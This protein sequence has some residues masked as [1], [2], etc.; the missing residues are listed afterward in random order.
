MKHAFFCV[1]IFVMSM[2]FTQCAPSRMVK[3]L[4]EKQHAVTANLG[5]P[6]IGFAGTVIPIPFTALGYGYG[7]RANT[8]VFGN[9]HTTSLLYGVVQ[10]DL[11][12]C[13]NFKTW[14]NG[15]AIS[16]NLV[17]NVA[18]DK[19]QRNFRFWP[20]LDVNVYKPFHE[21]KSF[22]YAGFDSW[23]ELSR[24]R[25]HDYRQPVAV[26]LN[27]HAGLQWGKKTHWSYQF[28]TKWLIPYIKNSPNQIKYKAPGGNGA[29][30]V[31]FGVTYRFAQKNQ[32][33]NSTT[34]AN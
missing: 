32:E 14:E 9:V 6:L 17:A 12:I 3:P 1:V 19:W 4:A 25:A 27:P 5:G 15:L 28:E 11:G 2:L 33:T 16:G 31:Y 26:F 7:L 30:G 20:Q 24:Y 23:Y 18:I 34:Q 29:I 22:W 13:Q 21:K 10:T 8:T